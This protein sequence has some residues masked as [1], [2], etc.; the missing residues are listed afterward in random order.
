MSDQN[1]AKGD[2]GRGQPSGADAKTVEPQAQDPRLITGGSFRA[3]RT[4]IG[5][6]AIDRADMPSFGEAGEGLDYKDTP[7]KDAERPPHP[8][9][10]PTGH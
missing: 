10:P 7:D 2:D 1:S 3:A 6:N 5:M 8:P 9:E 4:P